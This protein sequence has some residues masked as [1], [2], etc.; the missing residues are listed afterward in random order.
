MRL[1]WN[2][3]SRLRNICFHIPASLYTTE[4][5]AQ[6]V[7]CAQVFGTLIFTYLPVCSLLRIR[8]MLQ[9]RLRGLRSVFSRLRSH[10]PMFSGLRS[11]GPMFSGLRSR[12][13]VFSRTYQPERCRGSCPPPPPPCSRNGLGY[14]PISLS[15]TEG[16]AHLLHGLVVHTGVR[17]RVVLVVLIV[18]VEGRTD[19]T[20]HL[21][22]L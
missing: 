7:T 18:T 19:H 20:Q 9:P 17:V 8:P 13:P 5:K 4:S 15:T 3:Y 16:P 22:L 1:R 14:L 21:L 6:A 10:G 12:V 2:L 11:Q